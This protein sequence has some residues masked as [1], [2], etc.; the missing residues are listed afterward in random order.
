[1]RENL[2][3]KAQMKRGALGLHKIS[4]WMAHQP[5]KTIR[6]NVSALS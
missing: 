1:M 5:G 3:I 4:M 2:D 6:D